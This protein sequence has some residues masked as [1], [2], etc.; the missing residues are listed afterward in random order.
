MRTKL[1]SGLF[2]III[3]FLSYN[4]LN[5]RKLTF[6]AKSSTAEEE[7]KLQFRR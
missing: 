4:L 5:I 7:L 3:C 1:H 2:I 6:P